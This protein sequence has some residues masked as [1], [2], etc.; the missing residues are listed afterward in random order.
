MDRVL[1]SGGTGLIGKHLTAKLKE[2]GYN[3]ALLSRNTGQKTGLQLYHWD[4]GKSEI[5]SGAISDAD[6]IIHLAGANIG[7]RRWTR[8]RRKLILESRVK[9][10]DLLLRSVTANN[11]KLKA[12][13]SA[14]AVG[15]YGAITSDKIFYEEDPPSSDF[16]G[17]TCLKWEQ[18]ADRFEEKGI[19]TIKIRT[20]VV[21]SSH[22]GALAKMIIPVKMGV[23][24]AIGNGEQYMTWIHVEDL[25]NIYVK[26]I[27]D[28]KMRGAYNAAAPDHRTNKEFTKSLAQALRKPF[29]FPNIPAFALK[30]L[31]GEMSDILL[32][33]SRV[34]SEKLISEGYSFKFPDLENA[35]NNL[36]R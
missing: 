14:S 32:K 16:L 19:R 25:C 18:S 11:N 30:I 8:E 24:S 36:F 27:E 2:K 21:L 15:Y 28:V 5:D 4:P 3:V 23:G 31:F 6:F 34:S 1:I 35:L 26:A 12:F 13:I 9:S 7:E 29:W 22:G 33:G 20:G 17:E 10:G